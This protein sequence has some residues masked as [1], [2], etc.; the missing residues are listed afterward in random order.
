MPDLPA[1]RAARLSGACLAG[2]LAA[3]AYGNAVGDGFVLD[4]AAAIAGNRA[5][6]RAPATLWARD[7]WGGRR[8]RPRTDAYRPL[9]SATFALD[10]RL[11]GGAPWPFHLTNLVLHGLRTALLVAGLWTLATPR[12]ALMAGALFAV[13]PLH[14]E[15][16]AGLVGRADVLATLL[17][18][19]A[20][21]LH[22]RRATMATLLAPLCL[23]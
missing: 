3:A 13:H 19:L 1:S 10:W 15:A 16:V 23:A 4:D 2:L 9:T 17:G 22:R 12:V 11:G 6:T 5:V 21:W 8:E 18:A 20:W 14:T 7:F